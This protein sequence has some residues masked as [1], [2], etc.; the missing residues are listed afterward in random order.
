M[1]HAEHDKGRTRSS[2]AREDGKGGRVCAE[3]GSLRVGNK[4]PKSLVFSSMR[5]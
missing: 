2:S 4:L 3:E 1:S 5:R